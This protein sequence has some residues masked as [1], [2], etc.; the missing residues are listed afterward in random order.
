MQFFGEARGRWPLI[1]DLAEVIHEL[2]YL[3]FV[4]PPFQKR[5]ELTLDCSI[6]KARDLDLTLVLFEKF[7]ALS[8]R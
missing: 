2:G 3:K 4:S 7:S 6:E 5:Q 8:R 1:R